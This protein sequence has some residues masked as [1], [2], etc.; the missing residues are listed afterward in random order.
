MDA[1]QQK[2][3]L[4]QV[5]LARLRA[6]PGA[7]RAANSAALRA[8]LCPIL[9]EMQASF[10]RPLRLALYAPLPHE[11][12]LLPLLAEHSQHAYAFP[13][14]L[15]GRQLAFHVVKEPA[16]ELVEG[17]LGILAPLPSLP[18]AEPESLDLVLVPGVAFSPDGSRLGYGG[19]YYDRFLPRCTRARLLA[20]AFEEQ[21][22]PNGAI[23]C[24]AHDLRVAQV[25]F[26]STNM[27]AP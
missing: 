25:I 5:L 24:E 27:Q 16:R 11:V 6:I 18:Q 12:D 1:T 8:L 14:C 10:G 21:M 19:G 17:A 23:P 20:L 7:Q 3:E 2:A 9:E 15:P 22:L 4:R 26:P 13:R